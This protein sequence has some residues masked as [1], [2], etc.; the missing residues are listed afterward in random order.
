MKP[1]YR[2]DT[3]SGNGG[4]VAYSYDDQFAKGVMFPFTT[5]ADMIDWLM[6]E[7]GVELSEIAALRHKAP[8]TSAAPRN[9]LHRTTINPEDDGA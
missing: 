9:V 8:E 1:E 7:M 3:K 5:R 2:I 6:R 4:A